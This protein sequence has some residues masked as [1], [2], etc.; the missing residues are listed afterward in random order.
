LSDNEIFRQITA[1][2]PLYLRNAETS[3][4]LETYT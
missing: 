2:A 4:G 3:F 1:V